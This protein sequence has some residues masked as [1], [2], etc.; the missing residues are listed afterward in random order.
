MAK[1]HRNCLESCMY[2]VGRSYF[3][4]RIEGASC[5]MVCLALVLCVRIVYQTDV[6]AA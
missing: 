5:E 3:V 6:F 2:L 1:G 4:P